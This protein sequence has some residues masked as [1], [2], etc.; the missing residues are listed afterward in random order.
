MLLGF[1]FL[2]LVFGGVF[3]SVQVAAVLAGIGGGIAALAV[4][5]PPVAAPVYIVWDTVTRGIGWFNTRV[6][7][8]VLFYVAVAPTGLVLR[9]FGKDPLARRRDATEGTYWSDRTRRVEKERYERQF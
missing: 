3:R 5:M 4:V 1:G 7:L 6:I 9:L 2:A 8:V